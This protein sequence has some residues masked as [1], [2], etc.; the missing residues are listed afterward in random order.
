MRYIHACSDKV[1]IILQKYNTERKMP[2]L[3]GTYS[4]AVHG[5]SRTFL[6]T[7]SKL[8]STDSI[9]LSYNHIETQDLLS[10]VFKIAF[11]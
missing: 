2:G 8:T 6:D 1:C 9:T 3:L 4:T 7:G 11:Y 5:S 10:H